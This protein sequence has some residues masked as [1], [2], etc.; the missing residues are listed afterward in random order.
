MP[1][2]IAKKV[3]GDLA[4]LGGEVIKE[5]VRQPREMARTAGEQTGMLPRK[6]ESGPQVSSQEIEE[7][8]KEREKKLKF[9]RERRE[10]L[11]KPPQSKPEEV[12]EEQIEAQKKLAEEAK[13]EKSLPEVPT[14]K[15]R[16]SAF[17]PRRMKKHQGTGEISRGISG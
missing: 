4:E 13:K 11:T 7:K 15:P 2:K 1:K 5:A 6:Q 8:R 9:W 17:I 12:S 3:A 14:K 16:G 10:E